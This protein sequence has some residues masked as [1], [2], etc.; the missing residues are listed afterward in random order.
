MQVLLLTPLSLGASPL[1]QASSFCQTGPLS[2]MVS[3]PVGCLESPGVCAG[4]RQGWRRAGLMPSAAKSL[5]LFC[6]PPT[7]RFPQVMPETPGLA[8]ESS[9]N[10]SHLEN[11]MLR[12]LITKPCNPNYMS[13][14][15]SQEPPSWGQ[16]ASCSPRPTRNWGGRL[17]AAAGAP[18]TQSS[19]HARLH[20][21]RW[22]RG[23]P[24]NGC[25][26]KGGRRS[27]PQKQGSRSR[28]GQRQEASMYTVGAPARPPH[29]SA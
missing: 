12:L 26:V 21:K 19:L 25:G 1:L 3:R 18:H 7:S 16:P 8:A 9:S 24:W 15:V 27:T 22:F 20:R 2:Q 29:K 28:E 10:Y 17:A 11:S 13:K 23:L 4:A 5:P 6:P 14:E